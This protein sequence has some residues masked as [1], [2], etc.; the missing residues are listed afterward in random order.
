MG[1][2]QISKLSEIFQ[3]GKIGMRDQE[4]MAVHPQ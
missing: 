4:N 3:I 1:I 2:F